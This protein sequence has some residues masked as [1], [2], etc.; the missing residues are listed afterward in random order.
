[1]LIFLKELEES[2][3]S[4]VVI[5]NGQDVEFKDKGVLVIETLSNIKSISN[6]LFVSEINQFL[7]RLGQMM[8][9]NY[10]CILRI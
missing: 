7:L 3:Y 2:F 5:G 1:M 8:K 4:K 6:V 10:F 9:K